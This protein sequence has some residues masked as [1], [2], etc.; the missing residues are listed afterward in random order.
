MFMLRDVRT[1]RALR[2]HVTGQPSSYRLDW[3]DDDG[4]WQP[5]V[6]DYLGNVRIVGHATIV[7]EW[8]PL[9]APYLYLHA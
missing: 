9:V 7:A 1:G 2:D 5:T 8:T 4:D 3:R 6:T